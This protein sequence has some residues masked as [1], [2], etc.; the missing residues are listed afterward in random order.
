M[1]PIGLDLVSGLFE[2]AVSESLFRANFP[3]RHVPGGEAAFDRHMKAL[4]E[5]LAVIATDPATL[6]A[7]RQFQDRYRYPR[8]GF[9]LSQVMFESRAY[10]VNPG[11]SVIQHGKAWVLRKADRITAIP[12]GL[13]H[14]IA[15]IVA[16]ENFSTDELTA[17]LPRLSETERTAI[18]ASLESMGVIMRTPHR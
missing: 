2:R 5:R 15:W 8:G 6:S 14:A 12:T 13:D 17:A 7:F 4:A 3:R 9:D 18:L 16:H 1:P 10:H 11:F